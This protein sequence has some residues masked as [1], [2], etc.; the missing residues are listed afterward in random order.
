MP[1]P[2]VT[3]KHFL[4]VYH[5]LL[6]DLLH[7][8]FGFLTFSFENYTAMAT[9]AQLYVGVSAFNSL[10][11]NILRCRTI[12]S[13]GK[14]IHFP[15]IWK[16]R[17]GWILWKEKRCTLALNLKG[18]RTYFC[19]S[20]GSGKDLRESSTTVPEIG[21]NCREAWA[22]QILLFSNDCIGRTSKVPVEVPQSLLKAVHNRSH[23][24]TV[25]PALSITTLD[26]RLPTYKPLGRNKP[27]LNNGMW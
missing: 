14:L 6:N 7:E 9:D 20:L 19:P 24:L 13:H 18:C 15:F 5:I 26:T 4:C 11:Y 8:H 1:F 25:P 23:L 2:F 12:E 10:R 3:E 27:Y 17:Q 21:G 16:N 22:G